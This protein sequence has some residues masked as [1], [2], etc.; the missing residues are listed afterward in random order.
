MNYSIQIHNRVTGE[1]MNWTMNATS[2]GSIVTSPI[3]FN[4]STPRGEVVQQCE[5]LVFTV[6]AANSIGQSEPGE[7]TGGFPIGNNMC[8]AIH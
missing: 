4:Y 2:A 1:M 5:E 7:V 3:T 6:R 8:T